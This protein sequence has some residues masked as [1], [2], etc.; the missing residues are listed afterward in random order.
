MKKDFSDV[1]E[2]LG[3]IK[4][5][6]LQVVTYHNPDPRCVV[7]LSDEPT[8]LL[9]ALLPLRDYTHKR[10]LI[11]PLVV[12]TSFVKSSLDSFP[13]EFL[14]IISSDCTNLFCSEDIL[15]TLSFARSDLM[16]QMERELKSKWLLTRLSVLEGSLKPK[17]IA[18]TMRQSIRAILPV[19]KGFCQV[20]GQSVPK[21]LPE[22]LAQ[23]TAISGVDL[24]VLG[25]WLQQDKAEIYTIKSYVEL[26]SRLI[27]FVEKP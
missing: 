10:S 5:H 8:H 4:P 13:L 11:F 6:L 23:A 14:D 1:M 2:C 15:A 20:Q 19:L 7:I 3:S 17:D 27:D 9:D 18:S 25:Q 16:L 21:A 12:S 22:L 26:L 24:S